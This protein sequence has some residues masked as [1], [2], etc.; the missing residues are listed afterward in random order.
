MECIYDRQCSRT[1]LAA[2]LRLDQ[3]RCIREAE[4]LTV[5]SSL[6]ALWSSV[7]GI[8]TPPRHST[9]LESPAG[10]QCC[11]QL[12]RAMCMAM[13]SALADTVGT[14]GKVA[15][16]AIFMTSVVSMRACMH[17]PTQC[18]LTTHGRPQQEPG[19]H[20]FWIMRY[21]QGCNTG[22]SGSLG[23]GGRSVRT[24]V[25][26]IQLAAANQGDDS[27]CANQRSIVG[28][29]KLLVGAIEMRRSARSQT[30][31]S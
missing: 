15:T 20:G 10:T 11:Q 8:A 18:N 30:S 19:S 4:Q 25:G 24:A 29:P 31:Q 3:L 13:H 6:A 23:H 21:K 2:S 16:A 17:W 27:S 5:S 7:R 22:S 14:A 12:Q 9:A 1:G 26:H 28:L